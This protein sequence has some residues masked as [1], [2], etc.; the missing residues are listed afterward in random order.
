MDR[1]GVERAFISYTGG[2]IRWKWFALVVVF[3]L[4][5]L[6]LTNLPK[7]TIDTSNE[8]FLRA[9]DP[10]LLDYNRFREQFGREEVVLIAMRP[11]NIFAPEFVETLKKFHSELEE[12]VPHLDE[13]TSLVNVR[14]TVGNES[15]LLV[16]D[17]MEAFPNT[18]E[19][20]AEL[21]RVTLSHPFYK[22][23]LISEE[24]VSGYN[25]EYSGM[26]FVFFF[27][28][29]WANLYLI[30]AM[31]TIAFFGG[32]QLPGFLIGVVGGSGFLYNLL[33][34]F[35]FLSKSLFWVFVVMWLRWT[36]PRL[37]IDQL[38]NLCWKYLV[39]ISFICILGVAVWMLLPPV[40]ST[41]SGIL[42]SL[43]GFGLAVRM[44]LRARYNLRQAGEKPD[45]NI[46][47]V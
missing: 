6:L 33:C 17:L 1:S 36:L 7:I 32:W 41:I 14:Y 20:Y 34:F 44:L 29:E 24:L 47:T 15:E 39:P 19:G 9:D 16:E 2:L 23:L 43:L 25:T 46:L 13:V 30:G 40:L 31:A 38:M 26:R 12:Q 8:G 42:L 22:N 28:A 35:T 27:F 5:A 11:Q 45:W 37:R 10:I 3:V 4:T 18:P 21:R